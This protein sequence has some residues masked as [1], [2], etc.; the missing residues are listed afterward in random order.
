MII[1]LGSDHAGY[2]LKEDIK[3]FFNSINI[4][5]LDFGTY[6]Q[7]SCDFPDF[8]IKVCE[9]ILKK[10][11]DYGILV[12]GTG[13][14]MCLAAN[15]F[16]GIRAV[17]VFDEFTARSAKEHDDANVICIG[18]RTIDSN[19]AF[20]CIKEFLFSKFLGGKYEYRLKKIE[21][22]EKRFN[23]RLFV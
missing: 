21:A 1:A 18:A 4:R 22:I 19:K 7:E 3:M 16:P 14:G 5:Y 9:A 6:S 23:I 2:K 17:T 15:K 20:I 10:E 12:D 11:V 13:G 8:A